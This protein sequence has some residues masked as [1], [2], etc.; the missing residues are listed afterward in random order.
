MKSNLIATIIALALFVTSAL[1]ARGDEAGRAANYQVAVSRDTVNHVGTRDPSAG[2]EQV[3]RYLDEDERALLSEEDGS[4]LTCRW[5]FV[6]RLAEAGRYEIRVT[7]RAT[8]NHQVWAHSPLNSNFPRQDHRDVKNFDT[9]RFDFDARESRYLI[10]N[11]TNG[12]LQVDELT[13][14]RKAE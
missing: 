7:V 11:C 14:V 8:S 6:V 5:Y 2:L 9:L 4:F 3:L 12:Q 13:V 1:A 10:V